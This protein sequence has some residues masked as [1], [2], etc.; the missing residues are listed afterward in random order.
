M[1]LANEHET[2]ESRMIFRDLRGTFINLGLV[3]HW[4]PMRIETHH[5]CFK[6]ALKLKFHNRR[7]HKQPD[8]LN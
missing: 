1:R 8:H 4:A 6:Y 3:P 2:E 7:Q 5:Y